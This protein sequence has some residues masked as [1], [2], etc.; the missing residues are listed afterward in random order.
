MK[1]YYSQNK[2]SIL[3]GV[4]IL[5]A[6][7]MLVKEVTDSKIWVLITDIISGFSVIGI[8]FIL[9][10]YFKRTTRLLSFGY[11]TLK[12]LEGSLMIAGGVFF[13]FNASIRE[14]IYSNI[15]L[16]TFIISGLFLYILLYKSRIVPRFISLW[17]IIAIF[18]LTLSTVLK[19]FGMSYPVLD[20]SLILII[21]NEVFLAIWLMLKG[22]NLKHLDNK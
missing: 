11:L 13:I 3:A 14:W 19:L 21:T 18:F 5:T 9:F 16:Y 1:K 20:A 6:Y 8:A 15:H 22:F 10:P 2:Q 4:L 7:L 17:G 12:I